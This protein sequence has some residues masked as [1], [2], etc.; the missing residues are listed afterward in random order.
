MPTAQAMGTWLALSFNPSF[1]AMQN[2]DVALGYLT[3]NATACLRAMYVPYYV[4]VPVDDDSMSLS[5]RAVK[6]GDGVLTVS[7]TRPFQTGHH[8]ITGGSNF[9]IYWAFGNAPHNC[10][11]PP[12]YHFNNRGV[13]VIDWK[14]PHRVLP[15]FMKCS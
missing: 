1:P 11:Q 7:F 3:P 12:S 5:N 2:G 4:G 9:T 15:A 13:R 14:E 8:N 6:Y 10:S